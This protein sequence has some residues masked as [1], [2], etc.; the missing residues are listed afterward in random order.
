MLG[1]LIILMSLIILPLSGQ[2]N[3]HD[4]WD[5]ELKKY[6]SYEGRVNY[7][8]W[9]TNKHGVES[10]IQALQQNPPKKYWSKNEILSYWINAYNAL[11]VLLILDNYPLESIKKIKNPWNK[12]VFSINEINYSLSE[13]EH[14]ILRK[15]DEPRIH[16]AINCASISCPNLSYNAYKANKLETQLENSVKNFLTDKSKNVF[17]KN[18]VKLSK[19]FLW[20]NK[21]FGSKKSLVKFINLY[22]PRKIS[23]KTRFK[24]LK[25]N[26]LLN[27]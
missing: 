10:Y 3:I 5:N 25:Y 27:E 21:D 18:Q 20:F 14:N 16:F 6:V 24:Y 19:I 23:E 26:W 22:A 1:K 9:Q 4:R 11:T 8:K 2:K 12:K 13:I 15:M 17:L 7:K